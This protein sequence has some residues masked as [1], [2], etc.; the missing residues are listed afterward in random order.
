MI[1]VDTREPKDYQ[2]VAHKIDAIWVDFIIEGENGKF[3]IERK[4]WNDF[5]NSLN[6]GRIWE[7]IRRLTE[8]E[9]TDGYKPIIVIHG[10]SF[11]FLKRKANVTRLAGFITY[12]IF[13]GIDLIILPD[14]RTLNFFLYSLNKR[15]EGKHVAKYSRPS[16]IKKTGRRIEDEVMDVLTAFHGIGVVGARKLLNH[17]GSLINIFNSDDTDDVIS[18]RIAKH[19]KN[20]LE[21]EWVEKDNDDETYMG[22]Q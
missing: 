14:K 2:T 12:C 13:A 20:V 7:Q 10:S 4:T 22:D 8:L 6:S 3:A 19:M 21:Y 16:R 15:V 18:K 9:L 11:P 5:F 17:Y 1:I